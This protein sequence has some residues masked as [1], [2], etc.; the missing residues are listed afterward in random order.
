LTTYATIG[1]L[2]SA[3]PDA[4]AAPAPAP[5][6]RPAW[7]VYLPGAA[8]VAY[9]VAW[10]AGL[11]AW[12]VNLALNATA[13]QVETSYRAHPA[14]AVTQYLLVEGLAGVLLA[15]VLGYAVLAGRLSTR[16]ATAAALGVIAVAI[17]LIQCVIGLF[18]TA[19]ATGDH[20]GASGTLADLVTRLDGAK[21]LALA[22]AAALL[23]ASGAAGR[24][25]PRWIR[26]S[27]V[28]LG[29]ALIASGYAYLVLSNGLAWTVY[30]S[31]ALLLLWVTSTGIALTAV[32]RRGDVVH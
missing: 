6:D 19:A 14:G 27:T 29:L 20:I 22:C 28:P 18:L 16:T 21:M 12:P 10:A 8:G 11:A 2:P 32:R 5:P 7:R 23:A 25:L 9:L 3:D 17:S 13:A 4:A 15:I 26:A 31:G 1:P 30:I 24:V